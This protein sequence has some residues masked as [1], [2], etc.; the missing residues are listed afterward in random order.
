[1]IKELSIAIVLTILFSIGVGVLF[2]R[3]IVELI[4]MFFNGDSHQQLIPKNKQ[5]K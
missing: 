1:M 2:V 4:E 5:Q 3:T